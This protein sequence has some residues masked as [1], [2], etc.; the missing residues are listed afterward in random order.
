MNFRTA[1]QTI[2]NIPTNSA[3]DIL[4]DLP[5]LITSFSANRKFFYKLNLIELL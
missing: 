3:T 2:L 4:L 1:R 5:I